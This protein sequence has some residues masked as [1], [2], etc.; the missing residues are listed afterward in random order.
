MQIIHP[1]CCGVNVHTKTVV[2]CLIKHGKKQV[3]TCST[4]TDDLLAMSDWLVAQGCTHIAIESTGVYWKPVF[5]LL[6]GV[7]EVILVN[8]RHVKAVPGRKTDVRD[9]EWLA[10]L[11]RH[12]LL[13]ASFIPPLYIREIRE[14]TRYRQTLVK[15]QT[16]VANRVQKL[17]ESANTRVRR[18]SDGCARRVRTP[19]AA[20][21]CRWRARHREDR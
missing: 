4:M 14:L 12:G 11:L 9:C 21:A 16:A 6:E 3:R 20:C 18:S 5:N 7:L 17:I 15:E 19:D 8:A 13:K 2:A 1:C 10:D